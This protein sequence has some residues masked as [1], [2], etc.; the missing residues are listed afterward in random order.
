LL[1]LY[2]KGMN[3]S[4]INGMLQLEHVQLAKKVERLK[5]ECGQRP[6]GSLVL[7]RRG[8]QQYIYLVKRVSGKVVTE[9]IGKQDSWKAKGLMAKI[10]ERRKYEDDLKLAEAELARL[11]KMM[12]ASGVFFVEPNP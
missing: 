11:E 6:K 2:L 7:K 12:K 10:A 1:L 9:Y 5:N 8:S 4:A 3:F